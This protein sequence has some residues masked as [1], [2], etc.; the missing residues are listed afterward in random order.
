[1][2]YPKL[3]A[4]DEVLTAAILDRLLQHS[5]MI[6]IKGGSTGCVT[7]SRPFLEDLNHVSLSSPPVRKTGCRLSA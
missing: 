3:L 5:H 2:A 6:N 7:W 1:M 4:G